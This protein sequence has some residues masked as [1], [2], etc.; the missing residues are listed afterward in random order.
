MGL[1]LLTFCQIIAG[2]SDSISTLLFR[3][4]CKTGSLYTLCT[5]PLLNIAVLWIYAFASKVSNFLVN[6]EYWGF[7]V[8]RI[9]VYFEQLF[10]DSCEKSFHLSKCLPVDKIAKLFHTAVIFLFVS[11]TVHLWAKQPDHQLFFARG[12][13]LN[14]LSGCFSWRARAYLQEVA[15]FVLRWLF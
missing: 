15:F 6:C 4:Q 9:F 1:P 8:L 11:D 12:Y 14:R 2:L 10:R 3:T 5:T 7:L 13:N